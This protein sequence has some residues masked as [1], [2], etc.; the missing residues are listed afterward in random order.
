MLDAHTAVPS[1]IDDGEDRARDADRIR[2]CVNALRELDADRL[3]RLLAHALAELGIVD[4]LDRCA[5]PFL[6]ELGRSWSEGKLTVYQE[7]FG[8]ARLSSFM[9]SHWRDLALGNSG[10]GVVLAGLP[11][12]LHSGGLHMAAWVLARRGWQIVFVG[13]NCPVEQIEQAARQSRATVI[14]LSIAAS[15]RPAEVQRHVDMLMRSRPGATVIIG[16]AGGIEHPD[17]VRLSHLR[18]LD[19]WA[20]NHGAMTR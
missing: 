17:C 6:V 2:A 9:E 16:G 11:D 10:P 1:G 19:D 13:P 12:E 8:S 7:H 20:R 5:S 14:G 18:A 3:D 15:A 4:F